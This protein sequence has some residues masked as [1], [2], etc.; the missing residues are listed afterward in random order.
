MLLCVLK[1]EGAAGYEKSVLKTESFLLGVFVSPPPAR[2]LCLGAK[3][4]CG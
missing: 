3:P 1:C 2:S 4:G